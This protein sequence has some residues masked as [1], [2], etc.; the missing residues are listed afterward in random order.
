MRERLKRKHRAFV[1]KKVGHEVNT[2]EEREYDKAEKERADRWL[3]E[4][5]AKWKAEEARRE[6]LSPESEETKMWSVQQN[7]SEIVYFHA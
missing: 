7:A 1:S 3:A 4:F 5:D 2:D 6:A